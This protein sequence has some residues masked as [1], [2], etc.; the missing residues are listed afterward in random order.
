MTEIEK[1]KEFWDILELGRFE[2]EKWGT[3]FCRF[4]F[5]RPPVEKKNKTSRKKNF[6]GFSGK[7]TTT[8]FVFSRNLA[9]PRYKSWKT[10]LNVLKWRKKVF[11]LLQSIFLSKTMIFEFNVS[12]LAYAPIFRLVIPQNSFKNEKKWMRDNFFIILRF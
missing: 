6:Q 7:K 10:N 11:S 3:S 1:K 2:T 5:S 4:W 12:E 8:T 9:N